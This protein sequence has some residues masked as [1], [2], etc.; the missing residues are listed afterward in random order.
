[1]SKYFVYTFLFEQDEFIE[2][3][4][5]EKYFIMLMYSNTDENYKVTIPQQNISELA[6]TS[7]FVL[8]R[9]KKKLNALNIF[10]EMN[11]SNIIM[12]IPESVK[13]VKK[14]YLSNELVEG[15]Y[16][17]LKPGTK[18]FYV[19]CLYLQR[20]SGQSYIIYSNDEIKK[21]FAGSINTIKKYCKE[22]QEVDLLV[23]ERSGVSFSYQFKEIE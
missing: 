3:E 14:I 2:L 4:G 18:L 13:H 1:M 12:K 8:S 10:E 5:L 19:Y 9:K 20:L 16:R 15:K 21:P 6:N 7:K 22:L 11:K 17:S 23:R